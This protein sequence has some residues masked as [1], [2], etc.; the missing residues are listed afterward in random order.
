MADTSILDDFRKEKSVSLITKM[1]YKNRVPAIIYDMWEAYGFGDFDNGFLKLIDPDE[2]TDIMKKSWSQYKEAVPIMADAFGDL[3]VWQSQR[4]AY[5]I[6][7]RYGDY[8][9]MGRV[10]E[11]MLEKLLD[12]SYRQEHLKDA[13]YASA[14]ES[15]GRADYIECYGYLPALA[16]GGSETASH[17]RP[18][19]LKEHMEFLA[20]LKGR[21]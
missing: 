6:R 9:D 4:H 10:N 20:G 18:M 16:I 7:Y 19:R 13:M 3:I 15:M 21:I 2:Y 5:I 12:S 11:F 8:S 14:A 1:K 17:L